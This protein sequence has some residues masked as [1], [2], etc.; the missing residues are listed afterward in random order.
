VSLDFNEEKQALIGRSTFFT[1]YN[2]DLAFDGDGESSFERC[3][4][5]AAFFS[6]CCPSKLSILSLGNGRSMQRALTST[7]SGLLRGM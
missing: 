4:S 7:P 1:N 2:L 6:H 3:A 5:D